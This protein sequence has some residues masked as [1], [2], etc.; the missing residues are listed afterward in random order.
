M[1]WHIDLLSLGYQNSYVHANKR[2]HFLFPSV[3][4]FKQ[5]NHFTDWLSKLVRHTE[6]L[7]TILYTYTKIF[8]DKQQASRQ[9]PMAC[10]RKLWQKLNTLPNLPAIYLNSFTYKS[11]IKFYTW[12]GWIYFCVLCFIYCHQGL[13]NLPALV[14]FGPEESSGTIYNLVK[15]PFL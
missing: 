1:P 4:I 11:Q 12:S 10:P 15:A 7:Q 2:W 3:S 14:K 8:T 5:R 6:R 13:N 9:V